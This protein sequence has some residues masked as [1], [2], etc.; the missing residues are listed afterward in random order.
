MP[1]SNGVIF[2]L[3]DL[4]TPRPSILGGLL[5]TEEYMKKA[6]I[7]AICTICAISNAYA[8]EQYVK[9]TNGRWVELPAPTKDSITLINDSNKGDFYRGG[10]IIPGRAYRA[11]LPDDRTTPYLQS[12]FEPVK[13]YK[14]VDSEQEQTDKI[15]Q[16]VY[17]YGAAAQP[18]TQVDFFGYNRETNEPTIQPLKSDQLVKSNTEKEQKE[19]FADLMLKSMLSQRLQ[20]QEYQE[21]AKIFADNLD[22]PMVS[23]PCVNNQDYSIRI[24]QNPDVILAY[25]ALGQYYTWTYW[26]KEY[27]KDYT[28]PSDFISQLKT[29]LHPHIEKAEKLITDIMGFDYKACVIEDSLTSE[30]AKKK[31]DNLFMITMIHSG[32][33]SKQE[34]CVAFTDKKTI[35]PTVHSLSKNFIAM[36][37]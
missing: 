30:T 3:Y 19:V 8:W 20:P 7:I 25:F 36:G 32:V 35:T 37:F 11:T 1:E 16:A 12:L 6:L 4:S 15:K 18:R 17:L 22:N 26:L 33:L 9:Y 5:F 21:A 2:I 23:I 29:N 14:F 10:S 24:K 31:A 13:P 28:V 27:C 34:L